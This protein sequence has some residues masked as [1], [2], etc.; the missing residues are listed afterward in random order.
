MWA[1]VLTPPPAALV[2]W[3][4]HFESGLRLRSNPYSAAA[5]L[6]VFIY[7]QSMQLSKMQGAVLRWWLLLGVTLI[8]SVQC[9]A[10]LGKGRGGDTEC[11]EKDPRKHTLK[12]IKVCRGQGC[13]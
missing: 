5:A 2:C 11:D 13:A 7:K 12:L 8:A 3:A 1:G 10:D 4:L 9:A 6:I